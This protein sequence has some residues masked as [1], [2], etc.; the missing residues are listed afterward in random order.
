MAYTLAYMALLAL[1][2]ILNGIL[3]IA[4][5]TGEIHRRNARRAALYLAT[6]TTCL[7][8]AAVLM[9]VRGGLR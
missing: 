1:G 8:S 4:L 5:L 3:V 7:A 9:A 6:G 2:L